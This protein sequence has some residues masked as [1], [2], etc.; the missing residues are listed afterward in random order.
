MC[1]QSRSRK[2]PATLVH[3][4]HT[5]SQAA[6]WQHANNFICTNCITRLICDCQ[7]ACVVHSSKRWFITFFFSLK[8]CVKS[9]C[10]A[11]TCIYQVL[12]CFG[13]W[14]KLDK[15]SF[16]NHWVVDNMTKRLRRWFVYLCA[17]V[18]C[19]PC[20]FPMFWRYLFY[21]VFF[22]S[23]HKYEDFEIAQVGN[24]TQVF[25]TH[26]MINERILDSD[27]NG[28]LRYENDSELFIWENKKSE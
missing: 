20:A 4:L 9:A 28:A 25:S 3:I 24:K 11:S 17:I 10:I 15:M 13:Y 14:N 2:F 23:F 7:T 8:S 5:S 16:N 22:S 18:L 27:F 1:N 12:E 21:V 6:T 26:Q 19:F